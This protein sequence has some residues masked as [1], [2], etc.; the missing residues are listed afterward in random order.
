MIKGMLPEGARSAWMRVAR[1]EEAFLVAVTQ[2]AVVGCQ[3]HHVL[4]LSLDYQ[5]H[6]LDERSRAYMSEEVAI[7]E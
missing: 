5:V 2:L 1:P 4:H 3:V 6:H 7:V